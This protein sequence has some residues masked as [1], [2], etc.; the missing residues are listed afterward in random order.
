MDT[1]GD[2]EK[3]LLNQEKKGVRRLMKTVAVARNGVNET[4]VEP[5]NGFRLRTTGE[6]SAFETFVRI[7]R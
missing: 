4:V 2:V 3:D 5:K 1:E 6:K 7:G